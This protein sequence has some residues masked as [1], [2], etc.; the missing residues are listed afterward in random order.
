MSNYFL[1]TFGRAKRE[2]VCSCEVKMEPTL[3]QALHL[4]NGDA[5]NDRIKLSVDHLWKKNGPP[6][7]KHWL[8][9]P[10]SDNPPWKMSSGA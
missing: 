6:S 4:M 1:T 8:T 10:I 3:F 9:Q 2:S 7:S 5:V